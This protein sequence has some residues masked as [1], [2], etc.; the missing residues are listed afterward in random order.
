V[1]ATSLFLFFLAICPLIRAQ[2][3]PG[4]SASNYGGLHR[5]TYNPSSLGGSNYKWQFNLG[6]INSTITNRYFQYFGRNA[7]LYPSLASKTSHQLYGRS[8]T[9]GSLT[10]EDAIQLNSVFHL[11]S[12]MISFGKIHGVALQVRSR[13]F[14]QGAGIPDDMK[15][16]Y[17]KR[18]DTPKSSGGQGEWGPFHLKQHS[19]TEIAF[20]YGTLLL[21]TPEHKFRAG[22]TLKYITGG[23][24]SFI[25]GSV[26]HYVYEPYGAAGEN[27][28]TLHDFRYQ[29]GYTN[30]ISS[31]G[32]FSLLN[33]QKY[34][35]GW[36]FDAGVS[37]EIGSH[38]HRDDP[39]DSRPGYILRLA[40]SVNDV[41]QI[42]YATSSSQQF[43]GTTDAWTMKQREMETIA[44]FG[45][46]GVATLLGGESIGAFQGTG[47]LPSMYHLEADLQVFKSFFI[48]A[49]RGKKINNAPSP[50]L[51]SATL[52]NYFTIGPR[53]EYEDADYSFPISFIEG[54]RK[55]SVGLTGRVGPVYMGF[56]NFLGLIGKG[57][58]R[59]TYGYL[60]ISFFHLKTRDHRKKIKWKQN[61]D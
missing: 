54:K 2:D 37:Y 56:S 16:L 17:S 49:S 5:A 27:Q 34:G 19:F 38:W 29:A 7:L 11:P 3:L 10:N 32:G 58:T 36:A 33:K 18:L 21:N 15:M 50:H 61:W 22:A 23:R 8:R 47:K 4:L 45:P 1:R 51:L 9:M 59:A 14:V 52:P 30:P 35:Q 25:E 48:H 42:V 41:G 46:Q 6:T 53:W 26:D 12:L 24:S 60:G 55:V 39:G 40:A 44:D 28:I 20:S 43:A 13:G 57:E 31:G